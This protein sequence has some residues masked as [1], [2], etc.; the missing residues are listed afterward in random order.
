MC[1]PAATA[2]LAAVSLVTMP[3]RESSVPASPAMASISGVIAVITSSRLASG[4]LR[5]RRCVEPVDVGQKHEA[6][7]R[8]HAGDARGKPVI[9]AVTDLGGRDR[10]VLIDDRDRSELEKRLDRVARVEVAPPLLGVAKSDEDLRRR[11]PALAEN[12]LVGMREV[13]LPDRGR[14]L[15]FF[16]PERTRIEAERAPPERNGTRRDEDYVAPIGFQR[17]HIVADGLQPGLIQ[18]AG[19]AIGQESRADLDRN[20][21][22]VA[23]LR[24]RRRGV[25]KHH[26]ILRNFDLNGPSSLLWTL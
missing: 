25:C 18:R 23:P 26:D 21:A 8:H 19:C 24:A 20:T 5:G 17:G 7:G 3:P 13:D 4:S 10:V 15:R 2:I 14:G 22:C 1:V 16:K 11:K 12:G 9:V 6:I